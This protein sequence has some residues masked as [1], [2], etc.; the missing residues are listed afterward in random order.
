M[1]HKVETH[2]L[3]ATKNENLAHGAPS[4]A[5][6]NCGSTKTYHLILC[7]QIVKE[8]IISE[9]E[10]QSGPL[11]TVGNGNTPQRS[12][13][14]GTLPHLTSTSSSSSPPTLPQQIP[15][16]SSSSLLTPEYIKKFQNK[17][18]TKHLAWK[19]ER[20]AVSFI[21]EI[22]VARDVY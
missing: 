2:K 10:I 6:N 20:R 16:S 18:L 7:E 1:V 19:D 13:S 5:N 15:T 12:F 21:C 4:N 8:V 17:K 3:L 14:T 22:K 11:G 9:R